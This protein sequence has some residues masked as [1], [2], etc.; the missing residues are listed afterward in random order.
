MPWGVKIRR[1]CHRVI[2]KKV[3]SMQDAGLHVPEFI[4]IIPLQIPKAMLTYQLAAIN[5]K[6]MGN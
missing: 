2:G 6:T 5:D 3:F 4:L 1:A